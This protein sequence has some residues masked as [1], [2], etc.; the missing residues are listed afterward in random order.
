MSGMS[1][2]VTERLAQIR[3]ERRPKLQ[4]LRRVPNGMQNTLPTQGSF[5]GCRQVVYCNCRLHPGLHFHWC[6]RKA[7]VGEYCGQH[8][9]SLTDQPEGDA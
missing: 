8:Q 4:L 7:T 1:N 2:Y 9:L 3:K 5:V 6:K